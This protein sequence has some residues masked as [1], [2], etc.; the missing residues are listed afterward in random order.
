MNRK[1]H[2]WPNNH[3]QGILVLN[4]LD[5]FIMWFFT[6]GNTFYFLKWC[7]KFWCIFFSR[8][9]GS[10]HLLPQ[11]TEICDCSSE[12][13]GL[14]GNTSLLCLPD[15]T[16]GPT[17]GI[18]EELVTLFLV[19]CNLSGFWSIINHPCLILGYCTDGKSG[20]SIEISSCHEDTQSI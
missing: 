17:A 16:D 12:C 8:V 3:F 6:I 11:Q 13:C 18:G 7:P 9:F 14:A 19:F 2:C 15:C 4:V 1:L 5:E 10:F 20:K